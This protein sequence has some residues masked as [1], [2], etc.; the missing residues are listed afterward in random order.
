MG[1]DLKATIGLDATHFERGM[2]KAKGLAN[3]FAGSL[4]SYVVGAIGV[5][6]IGLAFEKTIESAKELVNQSKRMGVSIEQLQVLKKAASSAGMELQDLAGIFEK[7]NV[8]RAKALSGGKEGEKSINSAA[9][10]GISK[11]MLANMDAVQLLFGPIRDKI[12]TVNPQEIAAPLRELLGRGFGPIV[13]VLSKDLGALQKKMESLGMIMST[14]TAQGLKE[15]DTRLNSMKNILVTTLAPAFL[16]LGEVVLKVIGYFNTGISMWQNIFKTLKEDPKAIF[17]PFK[18]VVESL[19]QAAD[20][21]KFIKSF[22][23]TVTTASEESKNKKPDFNKLIGAAQDEESATERVKKTSPRSVEVD[24]YTKVGRF[25]GTSK[26][27]IGGAQSLMEKAAT[28]TA[29]NTKDL[30][31]INRELSKKF[32]AMF[33]RNMAGRNPTIYPTN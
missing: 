21:E 3:D 2:N 22:R 13:P 17:S 15:L 10:L 11:N 9:Q 33:A 5:T 20:P 18:L 28:D 19:A 27:M 30:C 4:K 8:F 25:L 23:S 32:D 24:Q 14:E 1:L 16:Y 31:A 26:G 29:R 6:S 7:L 12:K